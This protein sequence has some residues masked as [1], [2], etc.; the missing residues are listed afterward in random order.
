MRIGIDA[1][2]LS[3]GI[4]GGVHS[5]VANLVPALI[6]AAPDDE[7]Y[8]YADQKAEFELAN[9]P[10]NATV[11][12]L[13]YSNKLTSIYNDLVAMKQAMAADNLDIAHFPANYGFGPP[14]V[15]TVITLHDQI[16]V[17]PIRE[18]LRGHQKN[19]LTIAMMT[20]LHF[21]STRSVPKADLIITMSHYSREQILKNIDVDPDRLVV[22]TNGPSPD[23]HE[24]KDPTLLKAIRQR[25]G[26]TKPFVIADGVK[27]PGVL[28]EAWKL[29]P[30]EL[31][32]CYDIVFFSRIPTPPEPVHEAVEAG[33][34]HLLVRPSNEE[35][36]ALY[37]M[38]HALAFPSWY[39]GLGLPLLEAM[40][41]GTP[42]VASDRGS[43]PEV[44]GDAGLV[45]DVDD[46]ATF[47]H[48]LR[49]VLSDRE[50]HS[51]LKQRGYLRAAEFT[52]DK[53][54]QAYLDFYRRALL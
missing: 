3:H 26:L 25:F 22:W 43:I 29:L 50:V 14:G 30:A 32:E 17:L 27:N 4:V 2:Y 41:C 6:Q 35:L 51:H 7:F 37:S 18:I 40:I 49:T 9:L 54:A 11:R 42:V 24:V 52:W 12:Y 31:R 5:Y 1:R 8:L 21:C 16:N 47:S 45:C 44:I 10:G 34:A 46:I 33:Y 39:E 23:I 13:N 36:H 20:Y 53:T 48:N 38:A 28:V 19:P 15:R